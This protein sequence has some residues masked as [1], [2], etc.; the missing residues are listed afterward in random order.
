MTANKAC[1]KQVSLFAWLGEDHLDT[2]TSQ[3][4]ERHIPAGEIIAE[5]GKPSDA[6]FVIAQGTVEILQKT[7]SEEETV[8]ATLFDLDFFGELCL[9]SEKPRRASFRAMEPSTILKLSRSVLLKFEKNNPDQFA[10]IISNMARFYSKTLRD[11]NETLTLQ[12]SSSP[13]LSP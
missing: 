1:L 12:P 13:P 3:A 7:S 5:S 11:L 10:I 8:L 4:E 9:I 2:L 6:L